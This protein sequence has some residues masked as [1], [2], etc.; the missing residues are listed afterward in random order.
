MAF[1]CIYPLL[2]K[3]NFFIRKFT[4]LNLTCRSNAL[5]SV[6]GWQN[7]IFDLLLNRNT[8]V[9]FADSPSM[10]AWAK[11]LPPRSRFLERSTSLNTN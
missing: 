5:F 6:L 10:V 2:L 11:N 8:K 1:E 3:S 4:Q 9:S 7:I